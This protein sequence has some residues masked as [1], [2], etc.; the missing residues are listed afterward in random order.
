VAVEQPSALLSR[1][2]PRGILGGSSALAHAG[3]AYDTRDGGAS[4]RRGLLA[5]ASAFAA[6]PALSSYGFGGVNVGVRG[7]LSLAPDAVLALRGFYDLKLGGVPFFE[8]ALYEGLAYGEGLGGAGTIRGLARD[9]L[10][11][12]EKAL[13]SAEL[14]LWLAETRLFGRPQA[15]GVSLGGDAGRAGDR[16]A[17]PVLG[18]GGFVG[19]RLL[20]DRAVVVRLEA[21][22]AG[23]GE[24]AYYLGFDEAY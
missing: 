17:A 18:A 2:A 12:E 7:Y 3:I 8:R 6:P 9:R 15:W 24:L 4:P 21:G 19:G 16:G 10:M 11:G 5:D 20:W 14:R 23:Q 13:A 1:S 22:Y